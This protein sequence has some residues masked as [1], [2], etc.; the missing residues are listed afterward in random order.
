MP[1]LSTFIIIDNPDIPLNLCPAGR[2]KNDCPAPIKPI[3]SGEFWENIDP[4]A[5]LLISNA[6][7]DIQE[8]HDYSFAAWGKKSAM[9]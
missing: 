3:D 9:L 6:L 4:F 2:N 8:I 5:Q 1:S 7:Y